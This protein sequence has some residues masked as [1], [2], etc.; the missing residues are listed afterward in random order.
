VV[1]KASDTPRFQQ[2]TAEV[3]DTNT[4]TKDD[5]NARDSQRL[6]VSLDG[7]GAGEEDMVSG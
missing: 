7:N 6:L 4:T 5:E 1:G 2:S 3:A